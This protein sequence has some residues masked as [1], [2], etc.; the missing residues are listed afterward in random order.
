MREVRITEIQIKGTIIPNDDKSMYDWFDIES[1]CPNDVAKALEQADGEDVDIYINSGGGEIFAAT[2]IYSAVQKYKGN[3]KLHVTGLAASAASIIMCAGECDISATSMVMIH[4]VSS[5]AQGNYRDFKH[6]S[7]TLRKAD[8]AMCSAYVHKTGKS[9]SD[10]LPLMDKETWFTAQEAVDLGLCDRVAGRE[11]LVN[12][13][14]SI[15]TDQQR[16]EYIKAAKKAKAQLRLEK[17]K[18]DVKI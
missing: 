2:E 10:I 6:E 4:N 5:T 13:Y 15:V 11:T 3:V 17:I 9:E 8:K 7:E 16:N 18:G 1:T 12:A 14:C